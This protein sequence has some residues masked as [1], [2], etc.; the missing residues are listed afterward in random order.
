MVEVADIDGY[1]WNWSAKYEAEVAEEL[2]KAYSAAFIVDYPT[3]PM[4]EAQRLAAEYARIRGAEQIVFI[5]DETKERVRN[6]VQAGVQSGHP[7]GRIANVLH[8]DFIF[9]AI[10][11][12]RIARTETATALGQGMKGA[13]MAQGR[14]EKRWVT[15]GDDLVSDDCRENESRS[16]GWI[17]IGETFASGVDT[18]PQHP[19]CR[20][21]VRYRTKELE[22]DVVIPPPPEKPPKRSVMLEFRCPS[23][24][25]LLGRDVFSGTRILCRHCKA[26]RTAS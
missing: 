19:N 14:D 16:S 11:A 7:V 10:R 22:A 13:A 20:C 18:V 9:S 21:N 8:G 23:C 24:N 12:V 1:D 3:A 2:A 4:P 17:P 6:L 15:S 25:H 26:E 5:A